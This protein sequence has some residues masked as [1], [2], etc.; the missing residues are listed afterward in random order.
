[1]AH[2]LCVPRR[3]RGLD[4]RRREWTQPWPDAAA[5]VLDDHRK[6]HPLRDLVA[7]DTHRSG[8]AGGQRFPACLTDFSGYSFAG[9]V[10]G[11]A[12]QLSLIGV[13][14]ASGHSYSVRG[15][16]Q[17]RRTRRLVPVVSEM[18]RIWLVRR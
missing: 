5:S 3:P 9:S 10:T 13:R 4:E 17:A 18:D 1:V 2:A 12:G 16:Y 15:M 14:P 8:A 11:D 6:T 7:K